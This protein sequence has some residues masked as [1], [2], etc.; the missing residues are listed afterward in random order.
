M[1]DGALGWVCMCR[2]V[3]TWMRLCVDV[4]Y[5]DGVGDVE[6]CLI[7]LGVGVLMWSVCMYLGVYLFMLIGLCW[8]VW[9]CVGLYF[10]GVCCVHLS[11]TALGYVVTSWVELGWIWVGMC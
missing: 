10:I 8:I 11:S 7:G 5:C 4:S 9:C 6:L 1:D 3:L 2:D